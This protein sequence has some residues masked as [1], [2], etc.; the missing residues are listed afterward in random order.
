M[1][2]GISFEITENSNKLFRLSDRKNIWAELASARPNNLPTA[3]KGHHEW[4]SNAISYKIDKSS[5]VITFIEVEHQKR[6]SARYCIEKFCKNRKK[7]CNEVRVETTLVIKETD[8]IAVATFQNLDTEE[9]ENLKFDHERFI[10]DTIALKRFY[11]QNIYSKDMDDKIWDNLCNKKFIK[12]FSSLEPQKHFLQLS[13]FQKQ[14][15]N[16]KS[17]M[18]GLEAKNI[19]QW[20]DTY[21]KAE[22]NVEK[23]RFIEVLDQSLS[24]FRFKSRA[25]VTSDLNSAIKAINA[26]AKNWCGYKIGKKKVKGIIYDKML[27][28][29]SML[30]KQ[31][32]EETG[33]QLSEIIR[34]YLQVKT[35]KAVKVYNLFEKVGVDKIKYIIIYTANAISELINDKLQKIIGNYSHCEHPK[36]SHHM[37]PKDESL[38]SE[39][40]AKSSS[41]NSAEVS[42]LIAPIPVTHGSNSLGNSSFTLQITS[43]E[44]ENHIDYDDVYFD[45]P[46]V[47]SSEQKEMNEVKIDDDSDCS[48]NNNSEE[49]MPDESDESD[50]DGYNGYGRYNEYGE[51]DRGYYYHDRR[52]ESKV[53]PMMSPIIFPIT[54]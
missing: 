4:D 33:L 17:V 15:Y 47:H 10:P 26:I 24:L 23:S 44:T 36:E 1:E 3:I 5:A 13:H 43:F 18:K 49:E 41:Q 42:E 32:S 19:V 38:I 29:L 6:L 22:K 48:H 51:R 46:M 52:Y 14:G 7:V 28:N 31:R 54:A 34:K 20:E 53:S 9:I 35:Q 45:N 12:H 40:S 25:K 16:E 37:L 39:I 11:M 8:F 50:D 2:A 21:Y 30:R 27:E